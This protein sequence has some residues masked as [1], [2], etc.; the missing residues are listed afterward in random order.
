[1]GVPIPFFTPLFVVART[2]GIEFEKKCISLKFGTI[3]SLITSVIQGWCAHIVE[4]ISDNKIIRPNS[5]YR[6]ELVA[7]FNFDR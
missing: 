5:V 3:F 1:V 7:S 6:G 2:A 4:Q